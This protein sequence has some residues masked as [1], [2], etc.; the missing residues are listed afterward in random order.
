M[1]KH[2]RFAFPRLEALEGRVVMD[3]SVASVGGGL[4]VTGTLGS[5]LLHIEQDESGEVTVLAL[6]QTTLNGG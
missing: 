1:G 4:V 5:D 3:V 2:A 6:G